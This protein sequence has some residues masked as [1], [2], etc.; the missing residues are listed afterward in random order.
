M[1][2]TIA[3]NE[4]ILLRTWLPEDAS[5]FYELNADPDV[6]R[7]TGDPPFASVEDASNFMAAYRDFDLYGCGRW[8]IIQKSKW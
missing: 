6:M 2:S 4:N 3:E 8:I 1:A 5:F 7:Y